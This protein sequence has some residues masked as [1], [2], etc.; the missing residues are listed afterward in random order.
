MDKK[1]IKFMILFFLITTLFGCTTD[2]HNPFSTDTYTEPIK[3]ETIQFWISIICFGIAVL[4]AFLVVFSKDGIRSDR[5]KARL[6]VG[7]VFLI[8]ALFLILLNKG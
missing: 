6:I 3:F 5:N 4:C 7:I 1:T 8:A 2:D